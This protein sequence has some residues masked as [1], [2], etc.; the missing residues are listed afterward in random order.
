M[1]ELSK[2]E[3]QDLVN[4]YIENSTIT[5]G[6]IVLGQLLKN[7]FVD[8][9]LTTNFD[10]LIISCSTFLQEFPA[11]YGLNSSDSY[12]PGKIRGKAII[13]LHGQGSGFRILN[14]KEEM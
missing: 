11:I 5:Y 10:P 4:R 6:Y 9:I 1:G 2:G 8:R 14:T 7:G 12:D 3:R 13:H